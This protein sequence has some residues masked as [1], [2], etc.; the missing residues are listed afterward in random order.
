[1]NLPRDMIRQVAKN[2]EWMKNYSLKLA[3]VKHPHTPRYFSFPMLKHLYIFDLL[4]NAA[5]VGTPPDLRR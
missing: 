1:M 5:T 2:P 4:G 3:V